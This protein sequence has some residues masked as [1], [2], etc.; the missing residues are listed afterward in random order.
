MPAFYSI[1]AE[2]NIAAH[3]TMDAATAEADGSC[4]R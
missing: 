2:N 1:D 4:T 3:P